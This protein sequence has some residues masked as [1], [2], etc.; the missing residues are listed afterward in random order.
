M[1][2]S[3]LVFE[4]PDGGVAQHVLELARGLPAHGW[5]VAVAGPV[6]SAIYP[7]L[8]EAGVPFERLPIGRALRPGPYARA[9]TTL[10]RRAATGHYDVVHVHSS[11][12]GAIA[13]PAARLGGTPVVYTPHCFPFIGP[14]RARRKLLA[15]AAERAL[16]PITDAFICV[17]DDER[18]EALDS[19]VGN[20]QRLHVVHNGSAPCRPVEADAKLAAHTAGGPSVG[21]IAV[22]RPQKA[23]DVFVQA[24]PAI[25]EAVP[26]ARLAVIGDGELRDELEQLAQRLGIGESLR[27]FGFTPPASRALA[28]LDLFVLPSLWEAF[29]ISV[30]EALACGVP[31][32]ASDV[33]GTREALVHGETGLLCAP[34]D[35]AS[36]AAAVIELLRDDERREKM[37]S[38][39]KERHHQRFELDRMIGAT[40]SVY[41]KAV[42]RRR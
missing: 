13:R 21:A 26:E 41:E 23:I 28:Q 24:A 25:L 31:Q 11:K 3:L 19:R 8:E 2:R 5:E 35:P 20:P 18:R 42:S 40:A 30:L 1:P 34:G 37:S 29:P 39:S 10:R 27:F 7:A 36:L 12:A 33:G 4:P 6:E 17:S 22:L 32:V 16:A 38:A 15:T 14:Q 9:T